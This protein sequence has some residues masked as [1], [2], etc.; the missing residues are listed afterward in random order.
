[1]LTPRQVLGVFI[2]SR[3]RHLFDTRRWQEAR[4]DFEL[5]LTLY[6]QSRVYRHM[7]G[8][9]ALGAVLCGDYPNETVCEPGTPES[10]AQNQA[11]SSNAVTFGG[12][13]TE[14]EMRADVAK[15]AAFL[16]LPAQ[17]SRGFKA[18]DPNLYRY[19]GNDPANAFDP[20]GLQKLA[21]EIPRAVETKPYVR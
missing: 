16:D 7:L 10:T 2:G 19:V 9:C 11:F 3:A 5:A 17:E 15:A 8:Q 13:F 1:T 21:Q 12:G 14:A 6:P 20:S 18:D 4:Q